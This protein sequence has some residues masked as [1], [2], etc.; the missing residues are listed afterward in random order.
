MQ[1]AIRT[2]HLM[3]LGLALA[4]AHA[5][6]HRIRRA[7]DPRLHADGVR[8]GQVGRVLRAGARIQARWASEV[9]SDRDFDYLTGVFGTRVRS[10]RLQLGDELVELEQYLAPTGEPIPVDSRS[11]DLWFQHFA[12]VVSDMEQRYAHVRRLRGAVDLQ[13]AADHP[14]IQ[15]GGG[16]HQG[17]QVQGSGRPSARA[18]VL[19]AR[20]GPAKWQQTRAACSSASTTRPSRVSST[21][22]STGFWRDL[23][24][25]KVAGGSLNTGADPGAARQRFRRG[26][27]DHR[28]APPAST[29]ALDSSSC[30]T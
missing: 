17:L 1:T 3:L 6:E 10:A 23:S 9:V 22:R 4:L 28:P 8:S 18:A 30:S 21:E 19:P 2:D 7:R 15:P 27:A 25:L 16:R 13:R 20:Q 5:G 11:N 26:G 12:V 29:K 24:G 14:R